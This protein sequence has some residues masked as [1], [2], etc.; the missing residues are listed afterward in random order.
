MIARCFAVC[1]ITLSLSVVG[2]A[3]Y[4]EEPQV[5]SEILSIQAKIE[6]V[7]SELRA[8]TD[9]PGVGVSFVLADGR[10]GVVTC[11]MANVEENIPVTSADR[12][13]AGSV[14]KMFVAAVTSQLAEEGKL[15]LDDRVEKWIG[16]EPWFQRLPNAPELTVRSLLNH[17]AGLPEY[18]DQAGIADEIKGNSNREWTPYDRLKYVLDQ[19]PLF[20]VGE[21][22]SYADTNYILIGLIAER[23][24]G[25]P[26]F[27]LIDAQLLKPLN[28]NGIVPS[29]THEIDRLIPGYASPTNPLGLSGRMVIDGKLII[30][31]QI[32]WAG[33][34]L[35]TTPSDLA[36]WAKFLFEGKAF[37]RAETLETMLSGVEMAKGRGTKIPKYGIGVMIR[38]SKW[39]PVYGHGG[40]FPGYRTELAYFPE[41]KT[42]IAVQFNTDANTTLKK[43]V[44]AYLM[45]VAQILFEPAE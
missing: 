6:K 40:W 34:G 17:T 37:R 7:F 22:W 45:D 36:R 14:G 3:I 18:Y 10:T 42:A 25:K 30:N 31:P 39:G 20:A 24:S 19:K 8:E 28:L 38:D 12:F 26:L 33:G 13:L 16:D 27:E 9:F 41:R 29:S 1:M 21:G 5:D 43:S 11:G 4:A 44:S 35:A 23:A 32:E 15:S 2:R